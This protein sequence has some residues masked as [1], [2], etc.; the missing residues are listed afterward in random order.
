MRPEDEAPSPQQPP[1]YRDFLN[2]IQEALNRPLPL[3]RRIRDW[4]QR[5]LRRWR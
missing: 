4:W 2:E 5:T 3:R 1:T